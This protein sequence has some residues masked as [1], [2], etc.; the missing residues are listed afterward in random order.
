MTPRGS[1]PATVALGMD[2]RRVDLYSITAFPE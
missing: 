2:G 1:A